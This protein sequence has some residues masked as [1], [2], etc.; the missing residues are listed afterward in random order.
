MT[1]TYLDI[2][3]YFSLWN[4]IFLPL[5]LKNI[6]NSVDITQ[7]IAL[8]VLYL[9][10]WAIRVHTLFGIAKHKWAIKTKLTV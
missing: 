7:V 10:V 9:T 2:D 8:Y 5:C 4:R 3:T 6:C 1:A